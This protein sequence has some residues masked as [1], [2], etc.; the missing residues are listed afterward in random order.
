[1]VF[2]LEKL[3]FPFNHKTGGS[4]YRKKIHNKLRKDSSRS[5]DL[6]SSYGCGKFKKCSFEKKTFK[7]KSRLC[8]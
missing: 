7:D 1:M 2:G 8:N 5:D 4:L 3:Y 6:L